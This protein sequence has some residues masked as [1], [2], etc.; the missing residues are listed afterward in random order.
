MNPLTIYLSIGVILFVSDKFLTYVIQK[1]DLSQDLARVRELFSTMPSAWVPL[2]LFIS[3]A[4]SLAI[5]LVGWPYYYGKQL[6]VAITQ[7]RRNA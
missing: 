2:V 1:R 3:I 6:Y 7:R 5:E 4:G